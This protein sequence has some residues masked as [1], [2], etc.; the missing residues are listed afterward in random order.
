MKQHRNEVAGFLQ[1][2]N[3]SSMSA[4]MQERG[5]HTILLFA[6]GVPILLGLVAGLFTGAMVKALNRPAGTQRVQQ[7]VNTPDQQ[8][9]ILATD[10][11]QRADQALWG[12]T[13]DGHQWSGDANVK[14]FF[15]IQGGKGRVALGRG[16][17]DAVIGPPTDSVDVT[18]SGSVNQFGNT[19]NLGVVL[20]WTDPNNW[21]KALIDG[22]SLVILKSVNGKVSTVKQVAV[23][24]RAGI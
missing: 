21:Y 22:N 13:S 7:H 18:M 16:P 4:R 6:L 15:S 19:A 11:F 5:L 1:G 9:N 3:L 12:R 10:T 8:T 24:T 23:K 14:P 20:R 17:L 2:E